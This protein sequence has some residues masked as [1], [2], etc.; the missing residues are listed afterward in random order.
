MIRY[1]II[2]LSLLLSLNSCK[3]FHIEGKNATVVQDTVVNNYF[4]DYQQETLYRA[5][6]EVYGKQLTGLFVA[7][8]IGVATHRM[9]FTSD[10][11]NT[12]FDFTLGPDSFQANYVMDDLNKKIIL[13]V[14]QRDFAA[15][16]RIDNPVDKRLDLGESWGYESSEDRK[17][18]RV[19]KENG[20]LEKIV[21]YSKYKSKVDVSFTTAAQG[22][23]RTIE[24]IHHQIDLKIVLTV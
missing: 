3:P 17:F 23:L 12:L 13:R 6:I 8:R 18:F 24:I 7:K 10:F 21:L 1:L 19:N 20:Q 16:V 5:R 22:Q 15:L 4:S 9:V 2:S 11:G 14:L